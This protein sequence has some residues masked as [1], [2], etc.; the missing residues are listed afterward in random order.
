MFK[1]KKFFGE[2]C[3]NGCIGGSKRLPV[4]GKSPFGVVTQTNE[5]NIGNDAPDE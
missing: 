4:S 1:H 5:Y 3:P 2:L